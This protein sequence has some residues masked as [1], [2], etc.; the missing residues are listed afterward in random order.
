MTSLRFAGMTTL[1]FVGTMT[2]RFAGITTLAF[3]GTTLRGCIDG[4]RCVSTVIK[5][6]SRGPIL[7]RLATV[8]LA[9]H[10]AQA[11]AILDDAERQAVATLAEARE[12][13]SRMFEESRREGY[14]TG[15]RAGREIGQQEG[16]RAAHEES[17]RRFEEQQGQLVAA[18]TEAIR[19]LKSIKRDISLA[20][21][22]H[23]L[24]FALLLA[25]KV[26]FAVGARFSEA[27]VENL[28]RALQLVSAKSDVEV[29]VHP[30]DL[31]AARELAGRV[32]AETEGGEGVT[33][34][35]DES[36]A[37]GGC[38]VATGQAQIDAT[39]ETQVDELTA[40][41]LGTHR[42]GG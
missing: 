14:E 26:T 1:R 2:P 30:A 19:E 34:L 9:D 10:L 28:A 24:D 20:A 42:D 37:R 38:R 13:A 27:A 7:R 36:I 17:T 12:Q 39:L 8:D 5:S 15:H 22:E 41:L 25:R 40:L 35:G 33:L 31:E 3:A 16:H 21:Q 32:L 6:G 11:K 29:R 4:V 18:F 23:V